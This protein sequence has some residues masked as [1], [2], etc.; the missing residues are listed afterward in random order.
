MNS[1]SFTEKLEAFY[2]QLYPALQKT[3]ITNRFSTLTEDKLDGLYDS[4]IKTS[5]RKP[6]LAKILM[7]WE[8]GTRP[9]PATSPITTSGV[10][11]W[12]HAEQKARKEASDYTRWAMENELVWINA[13]REGWGNTAENFVEAWAYVQS[14][15]ISGAK[16]YGLDAKAMLA[17]PHTPEEYDSR[18]V[19]MK[20]SIR[21]AIETNT[22]M[23]PCPDWLVEYGRKFHLTNN[24]KRLE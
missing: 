24:Q 14:L 23:V 22:V 18:L 19:G 1:I 2:G 7:T 10:Q 13:R 5:D 8:A 17:A 12:Q 15:L 4:I 9:T 16:N 21:R 20:E 3:E 11:P 6:T